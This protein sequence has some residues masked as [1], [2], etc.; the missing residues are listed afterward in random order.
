V[1]F[2]IISVRDKFEKEYI[3]NIVIFWRQLKWESR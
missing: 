2:N 3:T 1:K